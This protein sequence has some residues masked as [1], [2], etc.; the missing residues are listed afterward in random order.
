MQRNT[1]IWG[2]QRSAWELA[3]SLTMLVW[4]GPLVAQVAAPAAAYDVTPRRLARIEP[5]T[6][7]G[8]EPPQGWTHLIIK[9]HPRLGAGD[10]NQV[11][12]LTAQLSSFLFTAIVARVQAEP[13]TPLRIAQ[14]GIGLG[15]SINGR[16]T[17][18]SSDT[19]RQLGANLGFLARVV[20]SKSE[21]RLEQV[22]LVARSNTMVVIDAPSLV[23]RQGRHV[24]VTLRYAL[25]LDPTN[26]RLDTLLWQLEGQGRGGWAISSPLEWLPPNKIEDC[27]LHVDGNEFTL[28]APSEMAFAMV[29][30]PKGHKQLP[31]TEPLQAVAATSRFAAESAR[32]LEAQLREALRTAR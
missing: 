29:A 1:S 15:T 6:V 16:D 31:W 23:A 14:V 17:I 13:R 7:I 27:V 26:G 18:I 24:P 22:Q 21:D 4:A 2:G 3:A 10:L 25:V 19:Q 9:S 8:K 30:M 5:G 20:L 11:N 28:G 32:S 12:S